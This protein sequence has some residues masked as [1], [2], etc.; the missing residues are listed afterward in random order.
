PVTRI[1]INY[2]LRPSWK[3]PLSRVGSHH[4][5]LIVGRPAI[6]AEI[7]ISHGKVLLAAGLRNEAQL[8]GLAERSLDARRNTLVELDHQDVC[9]RQPIRVL[10]Q[11]ELRTLD[12]HL[13]DQSGVEPKLLQH[14]GK[15]NRRDFLDLLSGT[16]CWDLDDC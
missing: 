14:H 15:R 12:V 13:H 1:L 5:S 6:P 2:W 16:I 7:P 4:A 11:S 8:V 3:R 10:K 9:S